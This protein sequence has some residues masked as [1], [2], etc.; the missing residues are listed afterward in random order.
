M[1]SNLL[2]G[3]LL[4][5][6]VAFPA[7]AQQAPERAPAGTAQ[8][9][10]SAPMATTGQWRASKFVGLDVYNEQN[11]KLGDISEIL[12]DQSGKVTG[13]II[14]VGGFLGMGEREVLIPMDKLKFVNEPRS[15]A[16][17][18]TRPA[19]TTTTTPAPTAAPGTAERVDRPATTTT[20]TDRPAT[21][22]T[23]TTRPARAANEKWYP[24]HAILSGVTKDSLKAMPEF[25]Y[26]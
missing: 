18:T 10:T 7:L 13:V 20:T 14:G 2:L 5:S 22:T 6:V 26:N 9:T 1:R 16:T 12:L 23:T 8:T 4:A 17:T 19:T 25:K 15:S 3:G 21:T 24:D 11:E